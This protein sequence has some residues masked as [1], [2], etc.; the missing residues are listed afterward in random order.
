[1][2]L[3]KIFKCLKFGIYNNCLENEAETNKLVG[4]FQMNRIISMKDVAAIPLSMKHLCVMN[5]DTLKT[6][7]NE[8]KEIVELKIIDADPI[9]I[10]SGQHHL[11]TLNIYR[12]SLVDE[13]SSLEK[14][15]QKIHALKNVNQEH[16]AVFNKYH[17]EM[18]RLKELLHDIG[19]WAVIVYEDESQVCAS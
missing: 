8:P 11:T 10:A 14:K 4:C 16:I 18:G 13:Y 3:L 9:V 17:D 6:N 7:F 19:K 1:V 2:D 15:I 12:Q 5:L